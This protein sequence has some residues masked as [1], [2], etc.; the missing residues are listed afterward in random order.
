[1]EGSFCKVFLSIGP[2]ELSDSVS[3]TSKSYHTN[4]TIKMH[5]WHETSLSSDIMVRTRSIAKLSTINDSGSR[6]NKYL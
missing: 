4:N 2:D 5:S 1:M 6:S 3:V